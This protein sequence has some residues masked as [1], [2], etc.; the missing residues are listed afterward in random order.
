M[1][2]QGAET[3]E[4]V[5]HF[6]LSRRKRSTTETEA[7][8]AVNAAGDGAG[9]VALGRQPQATVFDNAAAAAEVR[10]AVAP[11][12]DGGGVEGPEQA[13]AIGFKSVFDDH[14]RRQRG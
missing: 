6:V 5:D 7:E 3:L 14:P 10:K 4:K 8:N 12:V 11:P 13:L 9:I 1:P 2:A